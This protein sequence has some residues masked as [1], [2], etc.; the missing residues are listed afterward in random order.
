MH[1]VKLAVTGTDGKQSSYSRP[2]QVLPPS[3]I[4][5][6]SPGVP[7]AYSG[8]GG[9]RYFKI[10]LP[11][12]VKSVTA[13]AK[14]ASPTS[15]TFLYLKN[16]PTSFLPQCNSWGGGTVTCQVNNPPAGDYYAITSVNQPQ[17]DTATMT[18]TYE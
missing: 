12:G 5:N 9:M 4:V 14:F 11:S 17:N 15:G 10:Q 6:V 16:T 3:T 8:Q 1:V 13:T 2:V 18:M 7:V